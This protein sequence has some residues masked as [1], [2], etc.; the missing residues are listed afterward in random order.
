MTNLMHKITNLYFP[1][2]SLVALLLS[3]IGSYYHPE[4]W[5]RENFS[6]LFFKIGFYLCPFLVALWMFFRHKILF[7]RG[8]YLRSLIIC[9]GVAIVFLWTYKHKITLRLDLLLLFLCALYGLI[10]RQYIKPNKVMLSFFAL[11]ALKY[12]GILWS[13]YKEFAWYDMFDD[14][15]YLLLAAPIVCLFFRVKKA[16]TRTFVVL[17]FKLFLLL[18][19]LNICTYILVSKNIGIPFFSF[20]T[21]NKGYMPSG[22]VLSWSVFH[23]P[24]FIAWVMLLVWGL[25]ILLGYR[26]DNKYISSFEVILYGVFL[27]FF[28]FIVQARIVIIG[29]PL[30]VFLLLWFHFTKKWSN[31]KRV[32]AEMLILLIVSLCVY[33]LITHI[34]YFFDPIREKMLSSAYQHIFEHPIIGSGSAT[35]KMLSREVVGQMHIHNDFL[36]IM[37]DLGGIGLSLLL[38]WLFFT[39]QKSIL[40][41]DNSIAF[42]I[43]IFLLLMNTDVIINYFAGI[44]IL[45]PFLIFI[46][47]KED[48]NIV[49]S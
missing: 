33:L 23:H 38:L 11:I 7:T 36:A 17:S 48:E 8:E 3:F 28:S 21:L 6:V 34:S 47:F 29:L 26:K 13:E 16:E 15:L 46:F 18:L 22:E 42:T 32:S 40:A 10:Y 4:L 30:C 9:T 35:E 49:Q 45:F 27:L 2:F 1:I 25:G 43:I 39:Y 24:S 41:K 37:I 19:T 44:L 31:K 5:A 14:M 12:L 20:F